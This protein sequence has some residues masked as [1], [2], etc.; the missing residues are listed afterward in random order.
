MTTLT[1][2][3]SRKIISCLVLGLLLDSLLLLGRSL[4]AQIGTYLLH[5]S[6]YTQTWIYIYYKYFRKIFHSRIPHN[7]LRYPCYYFTL[8]ISSTFISFPSLKKLPPFDILFL[9]INH[10]YPAISLSVASQ[11]CNNSPLLSSFFSYYRLYTQI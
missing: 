3:N 10:L 5:M 6:M 7:I 1:N 11:P 2:N 8:F 4:S 9:Q